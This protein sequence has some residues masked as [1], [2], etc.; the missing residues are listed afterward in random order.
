MS[1][2][3]KGRKHT[4]MAN[5]VP[6]RQATK[7]DAP[8]LA[9]LNALAGGGIVEFIFRDVVPGVGPIDLFAETFADDAEPYTWRN[10]VVADDGGQVVGELHAYP[11]DDKAKVEPD[12]RI[13]AER[14]SILSPID[15]LEAPGTWHISAVAVRPDYQGR[16]LGRRFL[17]LA[18]KQAREK[19]FTEISLHVFEDNRGAIAL[20]ETLGFWVAGRCSLDHPALAHHEGDLLLMRCPVS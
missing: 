1:D 13:P 17:Q 5:D 2:P 4:G 10:C 9:Y 11:A 15:R 3:S 8:D 12:P 16:G 18:E 19:A 7:A 6:F 14:F 20:Y